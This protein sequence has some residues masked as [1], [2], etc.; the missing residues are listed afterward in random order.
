MKHK[1]FGKL[2]M[3]LGVMVQDTHNV[4]LQVKLVVRKAKVNLA[5]IL[6]GLK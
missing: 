6:R 5:F 2:Q 1:K 3:D 4:N